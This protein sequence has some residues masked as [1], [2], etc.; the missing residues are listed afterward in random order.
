L[1]LCAKRL[2]VEAKAA[3]I[4]ARV[5]RQRHRLSASAAVQLVRPSPY[6]LDGGLLAVAVPVDIALTAA[7]SASA[8]SED[9]AQGLSRVYQDEI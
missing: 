7:A 6:R 2:L 4:G 8:S 3:S 5:R 9:Y 1:L